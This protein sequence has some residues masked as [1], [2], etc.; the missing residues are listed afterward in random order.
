MLVKLIEVKKQMRGGL[1]SLSEIYINSAHIISVSEDVQ[2]NQ[3]LVSE[4]TR[5]G[6]TEDI[7]FS[8]IVLSEGNQTRTLTVVGP[9]SEV[10]GKV[11]KRQILRG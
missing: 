6:L 2:A 4:A 3:N 10:H 1:A 11:K 9:P 7:R 5:L 8:K